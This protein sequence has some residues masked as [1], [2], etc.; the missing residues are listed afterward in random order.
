MKLTVGYI[1]AFLAATA[2]VSAILFGL[3]LF[4][5]AGIS[6]VTWSL[7]VVPIPW[8]LVIRACIL[9]GTLIGLGFICSQEGQSAAE[10]YA[11]E[12]NSN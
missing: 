1:L 5:V 6:F 8:W 3:F 7:P 9:G 4:F 12:T 11:N 2:V 10:D